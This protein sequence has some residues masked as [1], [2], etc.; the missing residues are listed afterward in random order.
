MCKGFHNFYRK[1]L[2]L[3]LRL[4]CVIRRF[5]VVDDNGDEVMNLSLFDREKE[6]GNLKMLIV[7]SR[8][9]FGVV[10]GG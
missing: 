2:G 8:F 10:D 5:D 3:F 4:D 6:M 9:E 7:I 1:C